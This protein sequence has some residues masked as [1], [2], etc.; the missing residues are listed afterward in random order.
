M[1]LVVLL[2]SAMPIGT[3]VYATYVSTRFQVDMLPTNDPVCASESTATASV[4]L[5]LVNATLVSI[6][7]ANLLVSLATWYQT[8]TMKR[9]ASRSGLE[10]PLATLLN[11]D[12][13]VFF[14]IGVGV[15][16]V[17]LI[18]RDTN[19]FAFASTTFLPALSSL[20]ISHFLL[21]LREVTQQHNQDD[22][23]PDFVIKRDSKIPGKFSYFLDNLGERLR[24]EPLPDPDMLW[25]D[26]MA[27]ELSASDIES[28]RGNGGN[29]AEKA[30]QD[31]ITELA[32]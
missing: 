24:D 32:P 5:G 1:T 19:A 17:G 12:G 22:Q 7:V 29:D 16:T 14:L 10:I 28:G 2:L 27:S 8:Y 6:I 9:E 23:L 21:S 18:V 11:K 4:N 25:E 31:D 20:M 13:S 15:N 26:V 3:N 30:T